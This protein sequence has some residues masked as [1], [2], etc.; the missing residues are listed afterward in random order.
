ME[1]KYVRATSGSDSDHN[2]L[3][4]NGETS[5]TSM[6]PE[7]K[8]MEVSDSSSC[9]ESG[10]SDAS[11]RDESFDSSSD[12]SDSHNVSETSDALLDDEEQ[13]L[14]T[15]NTQTAILEKSPEKPTSTPT[16]AN[17]ELAHK[18]ERL[19]KVVE[20]L[21]QA[22]ATNKQPNGGVFTAIH[23]STVPVSRNE[24]GYSTCTTTRANVH[25]SW[26]ISHER[27][28]GSISSPRWEHIKPFPNGIPANKMW[29]EWNRFFENFELSV[30]LGNAT[31]PV[32]RSKLLFLCLV[33]ELQG[34]VRAADLRPGL[35][36]PNCY[37]IFVSNITRYLQS[38]TDTAAEHEA[39]AGMMQGIGESAVTFHSRLREKVRLCGY[40]TTDQERFVRAQLLKGLR[41][42]DL[43]KTAR[44]YN[45]D[46]NFIVQ[47][48]T[49][50]EAY[51]AET[52]Q[53]S[54]S[55]ISAV[56]HG[57]STDLQRKRNR[58]DREIRNQSKRFRR[59][60]K[61]PDARYNRC[62]RCYRPVHRSG[63]ICPARDKNCNGCGERGHF[64]SAC[65][66]R[67]VNSLQNDAARENPPGW[68]DEEEEDIKHIN[69][70]SFNDVLIDCSVG[71]SNPITF[72]IDSGADVN[73]IGVDDWK[74]LKREFHK[75]RAELYPIQPSIQNGLH[76]Y[77]SKEPLTINVAFRAK[78]NVP[79]TS[80]SSVE[81][82][83]YVANEGQRSLLG[84]STASDMGLLHVGL[85][86]N[87]CEYSDGPGK[88][89]KM[90]GIKVKFSVNKSVVPVK[91]AYYNVPAAF[92][93]GARKRLQEMEN[94][95]IIERVTKAPEWISG[96][97]TVAKGK[98][99]FRLVV[100]MR[101]PNKAINR[102]YYRLPLIDEMKTILH[103][104]RYF[105][106]L[107]LS[108][109]YY[110]LEL[111]HES[112]DLTT[113]LTETG[114]YRFTRL[115]F[116]VNCAPEIFQREMKP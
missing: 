106:K 59:S 86:I 112:R 108:N 29:E 102:E 49:R 34:I 60:D 1:G 73:V 77:G 15:V 13:H 66:K 24:H 28:E 55:G 41:N 107:D 54:G 90:P 48:A 113:F 78:I 9:C 99:D 50:E 114:M 32:Q 18:I 105:S 111:C 17:L 82:T 84:R 5:E 36:E 30:S 38:M 81:T 104:A 110:H 53:P 83:F 87:I 80:N 6:R 20:N 65:R 47:S 61:R 116:G 39:F 10:Q 4:H 70:L 12:I 7:D 57:K 42:R 27:V 16:N 37:S 115:M 98:D 43:S 71:S 51:E 75:G 109:A 40:S 67:R 31:N 8:D 33:Q 68:T 56:H 3:S 21:V 44:I 52:A 25:D 95:G 93:E 97:S 79:G 62:N 69:A 94:L 14:N 74:H 85:S 26:N 58:D 63:A 35:E 103:G 46:T 96:M 23:D 92:R 76:A 91:N 100:N 2:E 101:G 89:P 45:N 72:L 11:D 22:M 88:F 64:L 19:E